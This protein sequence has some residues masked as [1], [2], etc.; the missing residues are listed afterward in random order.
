[1]PNLT[2]SRLWKEESPV[3]GRFPGGGLPAPCLEG[4]QQLALVVREC[5]PHWVLHRGDPPRSPA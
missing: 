1:M 4:S 5:E 2:L 3:P